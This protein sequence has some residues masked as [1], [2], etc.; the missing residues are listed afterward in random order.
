MDNFV[1]SPFSSANRVNRYTTLWD[2]FRR[3]WNTL[4]WEPEE[5]I[6]WSL[7]DFDNNIGRCKYMKNAGKEPLQSIIEL[8]E[9][10]IH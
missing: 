5:I 2:E 10:R 1:L 8:H 6:S 3:V 4:L 7:Q 9:N